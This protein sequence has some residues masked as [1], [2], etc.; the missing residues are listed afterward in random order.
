MDP[1]RC[2]P[3]SLK[4]RGTVD[5]NSPFLS[6]HVPSIGR[7]CCDFMHTF[8]RR[9]RFD[10]AY[11]L[12]TVPESDMGTVPVER[13]LRAFDSGGQDVDASANSAAK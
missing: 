12:G 1:F 10:A 4:M 3:L 13:Q 8:R 7:N 2:D 6:L 9:P 5:A 11:D